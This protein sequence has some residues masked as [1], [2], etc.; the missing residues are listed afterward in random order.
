MLPPGLGLTDI[1]QRAIR[2]GLGVLLACFVG[3]G[4]I[5]PGEGT[6]FA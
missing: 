3:Y 6:S 2:L 5:L 1:Q 4:V